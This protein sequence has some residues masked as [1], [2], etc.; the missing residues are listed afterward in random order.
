MRFYTEQHQY[1]CGIDLHAKRMYM[2]HVAGIWIE[3]PDH[4][5]PIIRPLGWNWCPV[6]R[7]YRYFARD[8]GASKAGECRSSSKCRSL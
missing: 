6:V 3:H 1:Y 8:G 2:M 5:I 4:I 7:A